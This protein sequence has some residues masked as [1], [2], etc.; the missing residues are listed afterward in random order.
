V[1]A[2]F[3][4]KIANVDV[5]RA[6]GEQI[7]GGIV[8]ARLGKLSVCGS[9]CE[10]RKA[11]AS[12]KHDKGEHN[13]QRSAFRCAA[14]RMGKFFHGVKTLIGLEGWWETLK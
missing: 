7:R 4:L 10:I 8:V 6:A 3:L 5:K 14:T 9:A 2:N 1:S 12:S 13:D 11:E